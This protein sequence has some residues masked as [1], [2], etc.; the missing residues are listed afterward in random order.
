M[1]IA[2]VHYQALDVSQTGPACSNVVSMVNTSPGL[3]LDANIAF[4]CNGVPGPHD[5]NFTFVVNGQPLGCA[6]VITGNA[7]GEL[8]D[9]LCAVSQRDA[10]DCLTQF[11]GGTPFTVQMCWFQS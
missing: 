10:M 9:I 7:G 8:T 3:G 2:D 11:S 5:A 1:S 4:Q 6:G